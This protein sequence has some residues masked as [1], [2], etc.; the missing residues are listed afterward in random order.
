MADES[1]VS[2]IGSQAQEEL[3]SA[4]LSLTKLSEGVADF[5]T[6]L[7][8]MEDSFKKGTGGDLKGKTEQLSELGKM[9]KQTAVM[10]ER[11]IALED[12]LAK[13][14]ITTKVSLEA[15]TKAMVDDAKAEDTIFKSKK[16]KA[17]AEKKMAADR[18]AERANQ[19]QEAREIAAVNKAVADAEK[20][21]IDAENKALLDNHRNKQANEKS[22][23][24]LNKAIDKLT[25]ERQKEEAQIQKNNSGYEQLK[26]EY[27]KAATAAREL[28]TQLFNLK[29]SGSAGVG[30]LK[31]LSIQ[32]DAAS[33]KAKELAV[34]LYQVELASGNGSRKIGNYNALMFETN[35]L[36]REMPNFAMSAR[37]G[38]MSLS[39]N[40]PMFADQFKNVSREIDA[41]TGK[42]K[43]WKGALKEVGG[44]ILSWQ[45]LL[46]VGI[47]IMVA[48]GQQIVDAITA[49]NGAAK[50]QE[51]YNKALE[52]T[53]K[54]QGEE[55]G[56][57]IK[58]KQVLS[59]S[60]STRSDQVAAINEFIRLHPGVIEGLTFE[61]QKTKLLT[62][63]INEYINSL[64][65][66]A[67]LEA[68]NKGVSDSA[69]E[70]AQSITDQQKAIGFW[71]KAGAA[72]TGYFKAFTGSVQE[73]SLEM[74]VMNNRLD[75]SRR[76]YDQT[77]ESVKIATNLYGAHIKVA[78]DRIAKE[79]QGIKVDE[80]RIK[81]LKE[82]AK[83]SVASGAATV[84]LISKLE[85]ELS[86]R[87]QLIK[88]LS[89]QIDKLKELREEQSKSLSFNVSVEKRLLD[90]AQI[91]L[92]MA[93]T[94]EDREKKTALI[95]SRQ[96]DLDLKE[97]K[98]KYLAEGKLREEDLK[99]DA[100]YRREKG[101][102]DSKFN[103]D[104]RA[105]SEKKT[106]GRTPRPKADKTPYD[107]T[108]DELAAENR[109]LEAQRKINEQRIQ[110]EVETQKAI[111]D[112]ETVYLQ[113][114]LD[115][116]QKM[117]EGLLKQLEDNEGYKIEQTKNTLTRIA[118][119]EEKAVG[120]RTQKENTLLLNKDAIQAE[121]LAQQ[122][123]YNTSRVKL[124]NQFYDNE[125]K[126]IQ[127]NLKYQL[128]LVK[129]NMNDIEDEIN[130]R[131]NKELAL[132]N[133]SYRDGLVS[134][135]EYQKEWKRVQ[136]QFDQEIYEAQLSSLTNQINNLKTSLLDS[137][138]S[139]EDKAV[140][141]EQIKAL[142]A[143]IAN[144]PPPPEPD[145]EENPILK[146]LGITKKTKEQAIAEIKQL[147]EELLFNLNDLQNQANLKQFDVESQRL[148]REK[149][150]IQDK[151][152]AEKAGIMSSISNNEERDAA[153]KQIEADKQAR[154]KANDLQKRQNDR[155]RAVQEQQN[156][157]FTAELQAGIAISKALTDYEFPYSLA[158]AALVA[159]NAYAN[160]SKIKNQT[161]P[162]YGEGTDNHPGG[163]AIVGDKGTEIVYLPSGK[164]FVTPDKPTLMDLPKGTEV[165]PNKR[166]YDSI[167]QAAMNGGSAVTGISPNEYA[168][169][170][171]A[172]F[173]NGMNNL[174]TRIE[175]AMK[176]VPHDTITLKNGELLKLRK[177]QNAKIAYINK[178]TGNGG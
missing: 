177:V 92:N 125:N 83:E 134:K 124:D 89:D 102:I 131:R 157:I 57:L 18:K 74:Q 129:S 31:S 164:S 45:T 40:F 137:T 132:L 62:A 98:D 33:K 7:A 178:I 147:A 43:G 48:Y 84:A 53:I 44:A 85:D 94:D 155:R 4:I 159:A 80:E 82:S 148:D 118:E 55:I 172:N 54:S 26:Q 109:L 8:G 9:I 174:G 67:Q 149:K 86:G 151:Y 167:N 138:L 61:E 141:L 112:N 36:M 38:F 60:N 21:Q 146:W 30:E 69:A 93:K 130:T 115:A 176:N 15:K 166:I 169:L 143:A 90:E 96:R 145:E 47:S 161:I 73:G 173:E 128:Q 150:L 168:A 105:M 95:K 136:R 68:A 25:K 114:R 81:K 35:Q 39:N 27:D 66:K 133:I 97:L 42:M 111:A 75:K 77:S 72:V 165:I 6:K 120:D 153:L 78:K 87:K 123:K 52:D 107:Y 160:I 70:Y 51:N 117:Q 142:Y 71:D 99:N 50:A 32:A 49:T 140:I 135:K 106:G 122:E 154:E 76:L 34:G 41:N 116:N 12:D 163:A 13:K 3:D 24:N 22:T 37:T 156:A 121:L 46:I 16:E 20:K 10:E 65:V 56:R 91:K 11:I 59:D 127:S 139:E 19:K 64:L 2:I 108:D 104:L 158:I 113:D 100:N 126:I 101:L 119:I 171:V 17:E 175:K 170:M 103:A 88:G 162:A 28:G 152:D 5:N 110:Q 14:F 63:T 79:E 144:L 23:A 1:I 58:I 29:R